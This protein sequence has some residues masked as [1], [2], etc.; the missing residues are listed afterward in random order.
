MVKYE[1]LTDEEVLPEKGLLEKAATTKFEYSLLGRELIKQISIAE[2]QYQVLDKVHGLNEQYTIKNVRIQ[3]WFI[4]C[5]ILTNSVL[6]MKS[7]MIFLMT[8]NIRV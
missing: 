5:L 8:Q 1:F 2:K 3:I 7:L 4:T 6:L